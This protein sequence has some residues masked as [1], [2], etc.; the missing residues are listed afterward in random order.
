LGLRDL[1]DF[2]KKRLGIALLDS[3]DA[4]DA[5]RIVETRKVVTH[6]RGIINGLFANRT[7]LGRDSLGS[8]IELSFPAAA[9][10]LMIL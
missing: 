4:G 3:D 1:D 9:T 2:F 6:N 10:D 8:L 7:G 5:I